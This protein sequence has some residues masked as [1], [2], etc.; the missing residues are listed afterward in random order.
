MNILDL[1]KGK[2]MLI[3]TDALVEVKLVVES[4]KHSKGSREIIAPSHEN[5]GW[6]VDETW[7]IYTVKFTNGFSKTY[8]NIK[9]INFHE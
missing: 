2:C 9:D 4:I 1:A 7:D 6:G 5:D 8:T 3:M